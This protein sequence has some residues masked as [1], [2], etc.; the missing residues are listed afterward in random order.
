MQGLLRA[1][2][3]VGRSIQT[4]PWTWLILFS[5][6]F[7]SV[8]AGLSAQRHFSFDELVTAGIARLPNLPTIWA[9]LRD[10]VDLNPPL[11]YV[12]TKAANTVF[13]NG[14]AATRIPA[15]GGFWI[16]CLSIY[17][18]VARRCPR[19]YA[20]AAMLL[21]VTT[22]AFFF[23]TDARPYGMELGFLGVAL[24]AW[25]RATEP[26]RKLWYVAV[27]FF[28]LLAALLSHCYAVVAI[29]PLAVAQTVRD[30]SR[31][32]VDWPI[33]LSWTALT[34][35][36]IL[37]FQL[38]HRTQAAGSWKNRLFEPTILSVP[39]FY[40]DLLNFAIW[41]IALALVLVTRGN[42]RG[43]NLP[44]QKPE[45][46]FPSIPV[47]ERVFAVGLVLVPCLSFLIAITVT[48]M[49]TN[50]YST[51]CILGLGIWFGVF[52]CERAAG[53]LE[54]GGLVVT[55]FL[56]AIVLYGLGTIA[57]AFAAAP[58]EPPNLARVRPDLPLV[59]SNGLMFFEADHYQPPE[60]ASRLRY[61]TDEA[62]A[63]RYTNTN[64]FEGYPVMQKWFPMTGKVEPYREFVRR[65]PEFVVYGTSEHPMDWL[66]KRLKDDGFH[67]RM[68]AAQKG[69]YGETFLLVVSAPDQ[70]AATN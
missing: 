66:V 15:F 13:G 41:P 49:F 18:F 67:M 64:M 29:V 2:K 19:P 46:I 17:G 33:W 28:A 63:L 4:E 68:L 37:Y 54:K 36:L 35:V 60:V 51:A 69:E 57:F 47:H 38:L 12:V 23:A 34:P 55:V 8:S 39:L 26:D 11:L 58:N 70:R 44:G 22:S 25:Q 52:M 7:L 62:A 5:L 31:R 14:E 3:V 16:M 59:I 27:L 20:F 24:V 45:A 40:A 1:G 6:A 50:R 65:N 30:W 32:R 9:A 53:S 10:G 21:P 42:L 48:G 56:G 61:L 43:Q